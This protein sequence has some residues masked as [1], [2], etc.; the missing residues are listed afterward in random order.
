[1]NGGTGHEQ[2][3]PQAKADDDGRPSGDAQPGASS[4][5]PA[6]AAASLSLSSASSSASSDGGGGEP[7]VMQAAK[8]PRD[9]PLT[10]TRRPV[11]KRTHKDRSSFLSPEKT[12]GTEEEA[13]PSVAAAAAAAAAAQ[14]AE[15]EAAEEDVAE[16][17]EEGKKAASPGEQSARKTKLV[18]FNG[19][20]VTV[21]EESE[22]E[23]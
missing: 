18:V 13:A 6:A 2:A 20:L 9:W 7:K 23:A 4:A 21:D 14:E 19:R 8:R 11:A 3:K 1:V 22:D 5:A 10:G 15:E 12:K 17:G 16:E